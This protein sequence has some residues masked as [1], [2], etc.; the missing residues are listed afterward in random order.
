M[1]T[2]KNRRTKS[3]NEV[4]VFSSTLLLFCTDEKKIRLTEYLRIYECDALD[5]AP[6]KPVDRI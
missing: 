4:L 6:E 1:M 3:P 2:R 5:Y